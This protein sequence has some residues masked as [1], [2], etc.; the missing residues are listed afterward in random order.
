MNVNLLNQSPYRIKQNNTMQFK[1]IGNEFVKELENGKDVKPEQIVD[2]VKGTFGLNTEKVRDVLNE[3]RSRATI[4]I[5]KDK[6]CDADIKHFEEQL[7]EKTEINERIA[8]ETEEKTIKYIEDGFKHQETKIK[9]QESKIKELNEFSAKYKDL[10]PI[11]Y[12]E[13]RVL[14]PQETIETIKSMSEGVKD[15]HEDMLNFLLTGKGGEKAVK[16][17]NQGTELWKTYSDGVFKIPEVEEANKEFKG[18]R[19]SSPEQTLMGL[20]ENSLYVNPKGAYINA[21]PIR[22]QVKKNAVA[23]LSTFSEN[24]EGT[25]QTVDK[26]LEKVKNMQSD[27][28]RAKANMAA[29]HP[30]KTYKFE[31]NNYY[32]AKVTEYKGD[33]ENNSWSYNE[34]SYY[35][36]RLN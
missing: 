26:M 16:Y 7:A 4:L 35:F 8:K 24:P 31:P 21:G 30:D 9:E 10:T 32:D 18:Q 23:L 1:G 3:L 20:M 33:K 27:F 28:H 22:N 15:A 11:T 6:N 13:A 14:T 17:A 36:N 5:H 19:V 34:F 2:A 29:K 25:E 12:N